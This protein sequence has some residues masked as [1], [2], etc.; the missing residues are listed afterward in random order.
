MDLLEILYLGV[1]MPILA[2]GI[3]ALGWFLFIREK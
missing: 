2:A 3:L 1:V